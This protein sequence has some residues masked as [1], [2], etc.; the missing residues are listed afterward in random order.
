MP[1]YQ[2]ITAG[3]L[4]LAHVKVYW[5]MLAGYARMQPGG[6]GHIPQFNQYSREVPPAKSEVSYDQ[7]MYEVQSVQTNYGEAIKRE[8][9]TRSLRGNAA[10]TMR[11]LGPGAS[12][13]E[14]LSKLTTVYG[15]VVSFDVL[16]H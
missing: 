4:D 9:F 2:V 6:A 12:V 14:I 10:D 1:V 7:C 16:M 11:Y 3:E 13:S 15:T 8:A 5:Q